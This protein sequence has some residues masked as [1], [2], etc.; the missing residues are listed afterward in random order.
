MIDP[1]YLFI[2]TLGVAFILAPLD[3]LSRKI[4]HSLM[5][6]TLV[7][8]FAVSAQWMISF[9]SGNFRPYEIIT[10]GFN[11]PLSI[12][13]RM[14][15]EESF[16]LT[17]VNLIALIGIFP[18]SK[19][20]S[21]TPVY[22]LILYL[23]MVMGV[24]GLVMTRDLFN[25]FVFLEITS[26]ATY[27]LI[28]I[29]EN[30]NSLAAGFKY[31]LVSGLASSLLLI[32]IIFVYYS[33]G[34]LNIDYLLGL[35]GNLASG[36]GFIAI[37]IVLFSVLI[38]LK[39][40][41][42][43]GWAL[44][45]YQA[46]DSGILAFIA[47][48]NS[49]GVFFMFYK[50]FPLL[51]PEMQIF[52]GGVGLF[53]FVMSNL[54]AIGL[55]DAKRILGNSSVSQLGLLI[56]L[57]SVLSY[58]GIEKTV[59]LKILAGLFITN[60]LAKS[61]LFWITG[62]VRRKKISEWTNFAGNNPVKIMF[63]LFIIALVGLPPFPAFWSKWNLIMILAQNGWH[64]WVGFILL[65][66]LFEAVYLFRW[67]AYV[68]SGR[69]R[70]VFPAFGQ[71]APLLSYTLFLLLGL[72][73]PMKFFG[74][75]IWNLA[76]L[77]I[78]LFLYI[79]DDLPSKLKNLLSMISIVIFFYFICPQLEGIKL[80]F[81]YI[82][83]I[84]S[85][86]QMISIFNRTG[87]AEGFNPLLAGMIL[88]LGGLLISETTLQFFF[89][90]EMMTLT[91]YLLISRGRFSEKS[92]YSYIL[93]SL[94]GAFLIL[95]GFAYSPLNDLASTFILAGQAI[96]FT[97][98]PLTLLA[99]GFLIKT[100]AVGFHI[101]LPGSYAEAEDDL[102]AIISS[103]LSKA[104]LFGIM[105]ILLMPGSS[106]ISGNINLEYLLSWVGVLTVFF[107]ALM[108]VFQEDIKHLLAYSSMSQVGYMIL[109]AATMS[110]LGWIASLYMAVTHLLF[111]GMIFLA[112]AGVIYRIKTRYM[113]EM[114]GLIKK[115]PF[116]FITVLMGI[117]AL[118]GVPP[119]TG[120]GAKWM[121]YT[122]LQEKGWYLQEGIAFFSSAIAFL[123]LFR[124]IYTIFLGQP[125]PQHNDVKEA[126]VW[127]LI[128][129]YIFIMLIMAFSMRPELIVKPLSDIVA[130]YIPSTVHWVN[131]TMHTSLGYWNGSW[132]MY[133]TMGVFAVPL[134]WLSVFIDRPQKV[135]QFNIVFAAER[136][137]KPWTTHFAHNFFAHYNKALGFLVK[138]KVKGFWDGVSEWT[139][140]ISATFNQIYSGNGQT[141]ILHVLIY[142]VVLYYLA[143]GR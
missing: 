100:G 15:P 60:F 126:P 68:I 99:L 75:G 70:E 137:F 142:F 116:S 115:M 61:G 111:K 93:F 57:Y 97:A 130:G 56:A 59:M 80:I 69:E 113:Y 49:A 73:V 96:S 25:L 64:Y 85:L 112:I 53:T 31:M 46:A 76:P 104:G 92:A 77:F 106:I 9:L 72:I 16:V 21:S 6:L 4:S 27:T 138:P 63:T 2:V 11:L 38:E 143:G 120:F 108:A 83:L 30:R 114:G 135:K 129:Q 41:P 133:V 124:L 82:F 102:T 5:T 22:S 13:L 67:L 107:G 110:H 17:L 8:L 87:K 55:N 1:I 62:L 7:F 39:P 122:A 18:L 52:F 84:G 74:F 95:S 98:L 29:D 34:S 26:I 121:I 94:G 89:S 91:S 132:I 45:V 123:Y 43:N 125:K 78:M 118:S 65:G 37:F 54:T 35:K 141:Y 28:A 3:K 42:V 79:I 117:I 10:A 101:W 33:T 81:G 36:I 103:V 58:I 66:S 90:W 24:N 50:L 48:G 88:S 40:Y 44:D 20:F 23:L 47:V 128:P 127:F 86:I 140:S 109:M 119:L 51:T 71:V 12:N 105:M 139:T 19:R 136:P 14:G 32:G 131:G 134:I